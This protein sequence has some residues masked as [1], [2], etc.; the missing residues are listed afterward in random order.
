MIDPDAIGAVLQ[1]LGLCA[2][3]GFAA[4][5]AADESVPCGLL[6]FAAAASAMGSLVGGQWSDIDGLVLPGLVVVVIGE[7]L[8]WLHGGDWWGGA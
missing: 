2:L 1:V 8:A 4:G 3:V 6:T 5:V 7:C